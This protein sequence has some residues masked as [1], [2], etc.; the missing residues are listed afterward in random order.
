M[1]RYRVIL[2]VE[3]EGKAYGYGDVAEL[4][5]ETAAEFAHALIAV[6]EGEDDGRDS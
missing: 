6:E 3:I 4:P 1:R 2:P 5:M